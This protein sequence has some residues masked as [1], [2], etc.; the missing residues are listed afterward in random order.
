MPCR[1]SHGGYY[2]TMDGYLRCM[3][4]GDATGKLL[5][6]R[7]GKG[8]D[9]VLGGLWFANGVAIHPAGDSVLVVETLGFRVLRVWPG[10]G[11][12]RVES[13]L[14]E[15]PGFPDGISVGP[16]GA[17]WL[18]VIAP[19]TPVLRLLPSTLVRGVLA[20]MRRLVP[21]LA[22]PLGLVL[23]LDADGGDVVDVLSDPTGQH[24]RSVSA[25]A[26]QGGKLYLGQ[27]QGVSVPVCSVPRSTPENLDVF[28]NVVA[29]S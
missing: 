1:V 8:T 5:R 25:V 6:Y 24:V 11:G 14:D 3:M 4:R 27:L 26:E 21:L 28:T 9:E 10:E 18:A 19:W 7:P 22:R 12:A 16:G 15:V 2:D 20:R 13:F 23:R 29:G 17:I